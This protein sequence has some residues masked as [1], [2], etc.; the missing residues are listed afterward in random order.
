MKFS[1][2]YKYEP[3]VLDYF[4]RNQGDNYGNGVELIDIE[5]V[6]IVNKRTGKYI[7]K[8]Y[9]F[10]CKSSLFGYIRHKIIFGKYAR[11]KIG[12]L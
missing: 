9:A 5:E 12:W 10:L 11:H 8:G 2:L 3:E 6:D 7:G 4:N 1:V